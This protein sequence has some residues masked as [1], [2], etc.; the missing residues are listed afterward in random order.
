MREKPIRRHHSERGLRDWNGLEGCWRRRCEL[1]GRFDLSGILESRCL[2][3]RVTPWWW[4]S[5]R[6]ERWAMDEGA[7]AV[8]DLGQGVEGYVAVSS[9]AG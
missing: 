4:G 6:A 9:S 7:G 3:R 8:K 2:D 5:G 1:V